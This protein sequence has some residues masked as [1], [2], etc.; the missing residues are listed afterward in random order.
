MTD[1]SAGTVDASLHDGLSMDQVLSVGA[2]VG[3]F[4]WATTQY[5]AWNPGIGLETVGVEGTTVL[6][7]SWLLTTTAI[8]GVV[9]GA[10]ARAVQYSPPL[11]LWGGLVAIAMTIN[12]AVVAGFVPDSIARYALWHP[13]IV[14]YTIGYFATGIVAVDRSPT[15]YLCGSLGAAIVFTAW[16]AFPAESRSWVFALTGLVHAGPMIADVLFRPADS[17]PTTAAARTVRKP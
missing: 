16:L 15:A 14:V 6:I 17:E 9:F 12:G 11:W 10:G 4:G 5:V 7:L 2:I 8:A 3:L 1:D 13:W